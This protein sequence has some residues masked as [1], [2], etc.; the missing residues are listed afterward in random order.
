M[1]N[2][3]FSIGKKQII[4]ACLTLML[5][6]AIYVNYVLSGTSDKLKA[7]DVIKG[8]GGNYTDILYV[9]GESTGNDYF[10]QARIDRMTARDAATAT[11]QSIYNGGDLTEDE[12]AV[13]TQ[14]AMTMSKL[15]ETEKTVENLIKAAGFQDCVVYLDGTNASIVVKTDGLLPSE[16]AQI[17]E[18]LLGQIKVDRE[19]IGI[20]EIK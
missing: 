18:I 5:G 11:L 20:L 2:R 6:I 15:V 10:A 8:V 17:Y 13:I 12:K 1:K 9:S 16:A 7:T 3:N 19:N 14:N 4:L